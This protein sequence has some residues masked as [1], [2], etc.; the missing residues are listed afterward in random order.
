MKKLIL[1]ALALAPMIVFTAR[2]QAP[3]TDTPVAKDIMLKMPKPVAGFEW[4]YPMQPPDFK[5]LP[6]DSL[7]TAEGADPSM[8]LT[9]RQI[10]NGF[11][12]PD[13]FPKE[14]APMPDIVA[15]GQKPH[16]P[17]C[18]LCHLPNGNGHPESASVS[19]LS[20]QYIIEQMHAFKNGDRENIRV[21]AMAEMAYSIS[22]KDLREA[23]KYFAAIPRSQQKW[24]RVVET[25]RAPANHVGGGGARFFD[26]GVETVPVPPDMIYEVAENEQVE[27]RNQ[28]AGFVDYVPMGS[29]AKGRIV[30]TGNH[31]QMR[32]CASCH[33]EDYRGHDDAPRLAGRGAYYLIRQ[34]A[35]MKAGY[36]KGAALGKM[37]DV[38][39]KLSDADVLNVA[40]YMASRK[41]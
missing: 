10:N 20:V 21:P 31:G 11:G 15:H 29:L 1:T 38:V 36:R 14:H 4:A 37:K 6:P 18:M 27:L 35:D 41:P 5:P 39:N 8:T 32:T 7:H 28:H 23:A 22:E 3:A 17:A 19:G 34:L 12:P 9:M 40:A 16:V 30:A 24:I 33:G 26:N 2:A 25:S 13:W